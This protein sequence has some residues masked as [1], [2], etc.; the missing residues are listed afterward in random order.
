MSEAFKIHIDRLRGG[1]TLKIEE[2]LDS[3]FL[4]I[5]EPDLCPSE[6]VSVKGEAYLTDDHLIVHLKA[7]TKF[8]I[9]C[10]ICNEMTQIELNVD[11]FY[12]TEPIEAIS[13]AIYDFSEPLREALLIELPKTVECNHGKCPERANLAPFL[14]SQ[15]RSNKP[16]HFPFANL[17]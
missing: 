1:H 16:T 9:P 10:A 2:V 11:E 17:E 4:D 3:A 14:R 8:S 15:D 6:A 13:G 5:D 12:H 7:R